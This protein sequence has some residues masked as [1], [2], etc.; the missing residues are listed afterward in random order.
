MTYIAYN[1]YLKNFKIYTTKLYISN[2]PFNEKYNNLNMVRNT[3]TNDNLVMQFIKGHICYDKYTCELFKETLKFM[4]NT[5]LVDVYRKDIF[6]QNIVE[7]LK[8]LICDCMDHSKTS[9]VKIEQIID[10]VVDKDEDFFNR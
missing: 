4:F 10:R 5:G 8:G 9:N 2:L 6:D 7:L 1:T 3:L